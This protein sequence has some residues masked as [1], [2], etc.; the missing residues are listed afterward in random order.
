MEVVNAGVVN[1][2]DIK[3]FSEVVEMTGIDEI[4]LE[5]N[6]GMLKRKRKDDPEKLIAGTDYIKTKLGNEK[7]TP[8]GIEKIIKG[9]CRT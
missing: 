3:T 5:H 9:R 6:I 7:Y 2:T 4:L 8:V 1:I